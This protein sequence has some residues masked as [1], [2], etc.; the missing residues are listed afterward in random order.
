VP[1]C[2]DHDLILLILKKKLIGCAKTLCQ[3]LGLSSDNKAVRA[4]EQSFNALGYYWDLGKKEE[5]IRIS[6]AMTD[7]WKNFLFSEDVPLLASPGTVWSPRVSSGWTDLH[8]MR[9]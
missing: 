9:M 4:V 2:S 3:A 7:V 6:L 1:Q 8:V 5:Y